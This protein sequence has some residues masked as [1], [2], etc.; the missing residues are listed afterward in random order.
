MRCWPHWALSTVM[1]LTEPPMCPTLTQTTSSAGSLLL[2]LSLTTT[3][4]T[5]WTLQL[6]S[7]LSHTAIRPTLFQSVCDETLTGYASTLKKKGCFYKRKSTIP[8]PFEKFTKSFSC[9]VCDNQESQDDHDIQYLA[10]GALCPA[11]RHLVR[12]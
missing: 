12:R 2:S 7:S 5:P 8:I 3:G 9:Y 4:V 1:H 10:S 11:H 6:L